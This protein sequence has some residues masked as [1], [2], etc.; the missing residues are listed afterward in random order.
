MYVE[1]DFI[2]VKTAC[3]ISFLYNNLYVTRCS[4]TWKKSMLDNIFQSIAD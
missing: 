1:L 3:G 4:T 2:K